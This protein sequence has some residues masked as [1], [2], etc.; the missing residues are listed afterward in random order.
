MNSIKNVQIYF[1]YLC[2]E[3]FDMW[4]KIN[5]K[6]YSFLI[7]CLSFCLF[8]TPTI[9]QNRSKFIL[10]SK[11]VYILKRKNDYIYHFLATELTVEICRKLIKNQIV[12]RGLLDGCEFKFDSYKYVTITLTFLPSFSF[13]TQTQTIYG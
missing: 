3:M 10:V 12:L 4:I 9:T 11:H 2:L 7:V 6:N 1:T 5:F 8:W 13:L